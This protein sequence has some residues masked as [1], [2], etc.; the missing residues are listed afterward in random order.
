[1]SGGPQQPADVAIVTLIDGLSLHRSSLDS[2]HTEPNLF[3]Q[4]L[5]VFVTRIL[6]VSVSYP[7]PQDAR[8]SMKN[9]YT[10]KCGFIHLQDGF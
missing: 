6:P 8:P 7:A 4:T 10:E 9:G 1:M 3:A 5:R 2:N